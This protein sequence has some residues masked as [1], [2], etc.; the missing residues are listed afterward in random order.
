MQ[1][2]V[3]GFHAK[4]AKSLRYA[5]NHPPRSKKAIDIHNSDHLTCGNP[6]PLIHGIVNPGVTL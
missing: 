2:A 3:E 4:I 6:K 1:V 5:I